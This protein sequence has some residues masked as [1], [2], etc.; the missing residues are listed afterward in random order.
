M[1]ATDVR[2]VSAPVFAGRTLIDRITNSRP[3]SVESSVSAPASITEPAATRRFFFDLGAVEA[4]S[5]PRLG[6]YDVTISSSFLADGNREHLKLYYSDFLAAGSPLTEFDGKFA[7]STP[8]DKKE[9]KMLT[10]WLIGMNPR[11]RIDAY[12]LLIILQSLLKDIL[13][14]R[15]VLFLQELDEERAAKQAQDKEYQEVKQI[16]DRLA[17]TLKDTDEKLH[18]ALAS[19]SKTKAQLD[20]LTRLHD[21]AEVKARQTAENLSRQVENLEN[22]LTSM[23]GDRERYIA[24]AKEAQEQLSKVFLE[25][26]RAVSALAEQKQREEGL[27]VGTELLVSLC[28]KQAGAAGSIADWRELSDISLNAV[29][30]VT[31]AR[32]VYV[33]EVSK[34]KNSLNYICATKENDF[35]VGKSVSTGQGVL[36]DALKE[37]VHI[38]AVEQD[39]RILFF[40]KEDAKRQGPFLAV[41]LK[42]ESGAVGVV[43][44]DKIDAPV[45][46]PFS[47]EDIKFAERIAVSL[48][49]L[50][51][52]RPTEEKEKKTPARKK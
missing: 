52:L 25:K 2:P 34:Q 40:G 20:A 6:H 14:E 18:D 21:A 24:K 37:T 30:H 47:P 29:R 49:S 32:N 46:T 13:E 3:P 35:V 5:A 36:F 45:G 17:S 39:K 19:Q 28:A 43:G 31:N 50:I 9:I 33:A 8:I 16:S 7:A 51:V 12:P 23:R 1:A 4:S 15:H 44:L 38:P 27:L 26:D 41:P 42:N 10:A 22:S 11:S 48:I